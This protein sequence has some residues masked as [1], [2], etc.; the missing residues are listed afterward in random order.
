M[1]AGSGSASV[2]PVSVLASPHLELPG[3]ATGDVVYAARSI[4]AAAFDIS[5]D[6]PSKC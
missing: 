4:H 3:H 2:L 6:A 1:A 5:H